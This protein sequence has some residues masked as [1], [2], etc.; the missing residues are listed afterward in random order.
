MR[1]CS[2]LLLILC[3][4]DSGCRRQ[5]KL[6]VGVV[7]K[8][9]NHIFWQTV[10][11]GAVKAAREFGMEVEWN[12]PT[13]EV[14]SSR[15]IE[16]VESM[17]NRKLA[18]I[19]LAPVDKKALVSVVDRAA[20][21]GVPVSIFD[22][23]IDTANRICYVAT[24][25]EEGGRMAARRLGQ[26]LGGK[27]KVA[28]IGFMPGSASTM[29][30]ESGFQDELKL[31]FPQMQMVSLLF[32]MA[33]RAKA[34]AATE[35]VM[36]ANPDLAG[37]FADNESSSSGAV[38]ALKSRNARHVKLVAFDASEQLVADCKAGWIDSLVV[39]NPFR[40][41]YEATRAIGLKLR[42]KPVE[43]R[44]DSGARL[45]LA[46]DLESAEVKALLFPALGEWLRR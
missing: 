43:A 12:A 10:H 35:N 26:I 36:A 11:A 39:Q 31:K 14:D 44:I 25:N 18:G 37:L 5:E 1:V 4:L 23:G 21:M 40:M 41:G 3:L 34:M 6:V 7:P 19:V 13:L 17:V 9:A 15:Q 30:R 29:E 32:G 2:F 33:N 20:R 24:N 42:G 38:Q 27:G 16:I 45:I 28:L 22:S 46:S 8:G